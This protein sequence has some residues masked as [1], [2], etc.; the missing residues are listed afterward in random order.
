MKKMSNNA[1]MEKIQYI[2]KNTLGFVNEGK[3]SIGQSEPESPICLALLCRLSNRID[4]VKFSKDNSKATTKLFWI[5]LPNLFDGTPDPM[6][7]FVKF[8][9]EHLYEFFKDKKVIFHSCKMQ[10]NDNHFMCV[11]KMEY[12]EY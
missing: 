10:C 9:E 4:A 11:V 12:T 8:V 6:K 7:D 3:D 2:S 5:K 1:I